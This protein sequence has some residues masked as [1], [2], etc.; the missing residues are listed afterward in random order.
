[1]TRRASA[2]RRARRRCRRR[3]RAR[4]RAHAEGGRREL[5]A[6]HSERN[7]A[8]HIERR[9]RVGVAQRVR[10]DVDEERVRRL[11]ER[12][13]RR[14]PFDGAA[15]DG[16]DPFRAGASR[17]DH[18]TDEHA[19]IE[20]DRATGCHGRRGSD[21]PASAHRAAGAPG[22][23]SRRAGASSRPAAGGAPRALRARRRVRVERA[24][25]RARDLF[26]GGD[27]HVDVRMWIA[28]TV[29]RLHR[30][31]RHRL[32]DM[33]DSDDCVCLVRSL[34]YARGQA[35]LPQPRSRPRRDA[36]RARLD[37]TT[38]TVHRALETSVEKLRRLAARDFSAYTEEERRRAWATD[39]ARRHE[40]LDEPRQD[41]RVAAGSRAARRRLR[42]D[43]RHGSSGAAANEPGSR[44]LRRHARRALRAERAPWAIG[45]AT[46]SALEP[47][48]PAR[49]IS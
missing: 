48:M 49:S 7:A 13:R 37:G 31:V 39:R 18:R 8:E 32:D 19:R 1:M 15:V 5:G 20:D 23:R 4:G 28:G 41:A 42:R 38:D 6:V 3:P 26:Q 46:S 12:E 30:R 9:D 40:R 34:S 45:C 24:A 21:P 36:R 35:H 44:R 33:S 43:V 22:P 16:R 25:V 11:R 29:V 14:V 10:S 17:L 27:Q 2:H 47:A